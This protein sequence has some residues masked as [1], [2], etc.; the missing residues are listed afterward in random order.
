MPNDYFDFKEFR[1][2]QKNAAFKIGTDGVLLG[3]WA[4]LTGV[5]RVLDIGTGTGLISLMIAQRREADIIA[6][7]NDM[8]SADQALENFANSRW[9]DRIRLINTSLQNFERAS[10]K[11]FDLI[12]TNPPFFIGSVRSNNER[13]SATRHSGS[14]TMNDILSA[15]TKLL[16]PDGRLCLILPYA[17]GN[18][19]IA[20]ASEYKLY[21]NKELKVKPLASKP[22]KRMLLE[23]SREKKQLSSRFLTIEKG[24]RQEYS[25]EYI[26]LTK[27]FYLFM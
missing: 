2:E 18:L 7:E 23:F 25:G 10:N 21:C 17:E 24:K 15:A 20:T 4:D 6:I 22:V 13:V 26:D 12:I 1:V 9:S 8:I 11:P 14:L 3:A 19:F 16:S 5:K 27:D